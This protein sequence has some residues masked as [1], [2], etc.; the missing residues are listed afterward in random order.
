M[1]EKPQFQQSF[2]ENGELETPETVESTLEHHGAEIDNSEK[3]SRIDRPKADEF[4]VDDRPETERVDDGEQS[5]L[6]ADCDENQQSLSGGSAA[7]QPMFGG[8][9]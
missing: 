7:N 5:E 6:F 2:G 8:S 1:S 9:E 3:E 4:G